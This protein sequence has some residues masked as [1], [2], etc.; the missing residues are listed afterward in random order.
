MVIFLNGY[1]WKRLFGFQKKIIKDKK[2][3]KK[4]LIMQFLSAKKDVLSQ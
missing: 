3:I 2:K 4:K 1:F